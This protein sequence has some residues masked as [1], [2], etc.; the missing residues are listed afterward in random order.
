MDKCSAELKGLV[1]SETAQ[2]QTHVWCALL[3]G[4]IGR[5][6]FSLLGDACDL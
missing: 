1:F 4:L 6:C 3:R 2:P 5:Q